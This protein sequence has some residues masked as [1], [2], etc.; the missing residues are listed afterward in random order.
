MNI[1]KIFLQGRLGRAP[2]MIENEKPIC[3]F[4]I[5]TNNF[6]GEAT[7]HNIVA[8]G[9]TAEN[10]GRYLVAGQEVWVEGS[11]E[12][13]SYEKNGEK[14]YFSQVIANNVQFGNKNNPEKN[15]EGETKTMDKQFT[16]DE[17]P[18]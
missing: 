4:S 17:I 2:E 12:H 9:K 5:A 6:K 7:W 16:A 11:Q 15:E 3:K 18:F 14:K 8:F 1:N 10:C 13:K